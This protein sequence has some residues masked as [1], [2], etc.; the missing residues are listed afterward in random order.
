M[1]VFVVIFARIQQ[2]PLILQQ[3]RER[4]Q[5]FNRP[6]YIIYIDGD[7]DEEEERRNEAVELPQHRYAVCRQEVGRYPQCC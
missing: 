4:L 5:L 6:I 2:R 7:N 3:V 1:Y